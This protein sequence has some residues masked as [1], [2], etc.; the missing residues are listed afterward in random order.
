[1]SRKQILWL[2]VAVALAVFVAVQVVDETRQPSELIAQADVPTVAPG[3][4]VLAGVAEIPERVRGYDYRRDAFGEAWTDDTTAPGGFNGCDT[5][6]DVLARDLSAVVFREGSGECK[7]LEGVLVDPYDGHTE[8]FT[9]GEQTSPLV[10]IYHIVALAWAWRHGADRWSDAERLV[11]ANDP[12][13]LVVTADEINSA[14]SDSGPA[15]WMPPAAASVCGYVI[16]WVSV[17]DAY[18]LG[19][20]GPDREAARS[21]LTRC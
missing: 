16:A 3:V 9:S 2:A 14:K 11:F 17:V 15:E 18:D 13:N 5:R 7:V 20:T 10:Q 4:D 6:N 1:M 21:A 8:S 19:I 12:A